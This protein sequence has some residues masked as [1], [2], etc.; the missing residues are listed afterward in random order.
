M[1]VDQSQVTVDRRQTTAGRQADGAG[2]L[3]QISDL[4]TYFYLAEGVV[5]AVDGV[6]LT[7]QRGHTLGV[8]GE[9]G[10]GKSMTAHSIMRLVPSPGRIVEGEILFRRPIGGD[11]GSAATEV[12]DLAQLPPNGREI[13]DIR[14]NE[15]SMVFQEPMTALSPVLSVGHQITEAITLHQQV[16]KAEAREIAIDML[17]RVKMP[18]PSKTI[19]DYPFELS[20]GMRQRAVIAMALSCHPSLLIA[21]EPTTALDV[22]TEAQILDLMR[23]L[24]AELGM[25]IMYITHNLG[26]IAEMAEQVAVMY[27]GKVVE[28]AEVETIFFR[29]QHPYT[30][31]LLQS[32]PKLE[33]AVMGEEGRLSTIRGM[34][35]DPYSRLPGCTFH[36]RCPDFIPGTCDQVVPELVQCEP[37][38]TVRCHLYEEC[39]QPQSDLEV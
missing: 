11:E 8:V 23:D 31:A 9:S 15:I 3:I 25:A 17:A 30:R 14:G 28:Q 35:P 16:S 4:R 26:V 22:T 7:I 27:L 24:Q 1:T 19:D 5:R 18:N 38:H 13:R 37:Q 10:C 12:I 39:P 20:G 32:I 29:P 33:A 2:T 34:V 21:D 6:D 36:P